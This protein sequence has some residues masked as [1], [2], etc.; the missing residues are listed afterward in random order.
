MSDQLKGAIEWGIALA[1]ALVAWALI[2]KGAVQ[3][4]EWI[5]NW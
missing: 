1:I 5:V 3:L 4:A 2:A